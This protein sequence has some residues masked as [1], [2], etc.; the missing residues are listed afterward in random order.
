MEIS[1]YAQRIVHLSDGKIER[2]DYNNQSIKH[3]NELENAHREE[4]K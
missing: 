2:I 3:S 1:D 4:E